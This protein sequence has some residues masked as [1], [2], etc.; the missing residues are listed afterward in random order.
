[1]KMSSKKN[2]MNNSIVHKPPTKQ[3][4]RST[5]KTK[6][7]KIRI[8][9]SYDEQSSSVSP[10]NLDKLK[11]IKTFRLPPRY[12]YDSPNNQYLRQTI[13]HT[14]PATHSNTSSIYNLTNIH[15]Q[16]SPNLF[17]TISR[18]PNGDELEGKSDTGLSPPNSNGIARTNLERSTTP[19]NR[20][21]TS[22]WKPS[23]SYQQRHLTSTKNPC[24]RH[25][26]S[27]S[28]SAPPSTAISSISKH[29][30][31]HIHPYNNLS[32]MTSRYPNEDELE[33]KSDT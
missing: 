11:R 29:T 24:L 10:N 33:D 32:P 5:R 21:S 12:T 22:L 19:Q 1:M 13:F 6:L 26:T 18:C 23:T 14:T 16:S 15:K 27:L 20:D 28:T 3:Q 17:P 25:P 8:Q 2:M 7:N 9:D 31:I 4:Q 30:N